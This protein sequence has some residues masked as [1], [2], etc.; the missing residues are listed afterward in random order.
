MRSKKKV[1][2]TDLHR[3]DSLI[4]NENPLLNKKIRA[5]FLLYDKKVVDLNLNYQGKI[6]LINI[7]IE[8]L[9]KHEE[10]E[11]VK[12]FRDRKFKKFKK[13]RKENRKWSLKLLFRFI[14]FKI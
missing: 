14:K 10:Y 5:L 12:S 9:L 13:Y 2:E 3:F 1:K 4:L 6:G 7:F 11:I 8:G